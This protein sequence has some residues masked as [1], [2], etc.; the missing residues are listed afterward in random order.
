MLVTALILVATLLL[1]NIITAVMLD[2]CQDEN[3]RLKTKLED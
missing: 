2:Y 3:I 1:T